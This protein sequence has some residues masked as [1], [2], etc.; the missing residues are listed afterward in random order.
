MRVITHLTVVALIAVLSACGPATVPCGTFTF[1]GSP[2]ANG[3]IDC[4]VS[5]SFSP[6][7]CGAAACQC[8]TIAYIQ[9]VRIIDR[10]TGNYLQPFAE[11]SN[12]M[13]TGNATV[14]FNGW[15]V[16]RLQGR[17][18]GYYGRNNDGTFAGTLTP[19][20]NTTAAVLRDTPQGWGVNN[21]FDAVS[22]PVCIDAGAPCVN[23]LAGYEY[24]L[25]VV[26]QDGAGSD[27]FSEIGR[28][29]HR[30]AFN[31]AVAEWNADAP[32]LKKNVFPAMSPL[33]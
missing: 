14:A 27:P 24:W 8:N 11:Q 32:G 23:R 33:P 16:D 5:F 26:G 4:E 22:V 28:E 7:A 29:W 18:W 17:V 21:W 13:V 20:S 25:F 10:D 12:R 31:L 3:G 9:I 30:D 19:G 1:T 2:I 6:V 15:A